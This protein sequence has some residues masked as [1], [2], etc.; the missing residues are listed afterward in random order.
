MRSTVHRR[1]WLELALSG[2]FA[3][4]AVLTAIIPEWVEVFF[5]IEPDAGG[6]AFEVAMTVGLLVVAVVFALV[7]RIE[8]RGGSLARRRSGSP[9]NTPTADR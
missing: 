4:A 2:L 8:F 5:G 1:F 9:P 3:V 7:A 6:G